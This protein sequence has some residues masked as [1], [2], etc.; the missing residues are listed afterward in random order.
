MVAQKHTDLPQGRKRKMNKKP[1]LLIYT[2]ISFCVIVAAIVVSLTAGFN[3]GSDIAGGTQIEIL[4]TGSEKSESQLISETKI[5][6]K[7][8]GVAYD[9][10]FVEDKYTD[11]YLIVRTNNKSFNKDKLTNNLAHK[12]EIE[13]ED[14]TGI[15]EISG[16]V[17]KSA[18]VWI[19]VTLALLIVGIFLASWIRYKLMTA[20]S[21]T[22]AVLH[23]IIFSTS[24]LVV[25]RIPFTLVSFIIL[26]LFSALILFAFVLTFERVL[27]NGKMVHN[28]DLSSEELIKLSKNQTLKTLLFIVCGL[29]VVA[30]ALMFVPSLNIVFNAI[31]LLVGLLS[32]T[33]SYWFI[34]L[35]LYSFMLTIKDA[36]NKRRL[37][38][39]NSPAPKKR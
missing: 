23:S 29:T 13:V 27:E 32:A 17:T 18:V 14:I 34:G 12:L 1:W 9:K 4:V 31:S 28:K 10:V 11:T 33:Y 8:N 22:I 30:L 24:L 25:T 36:A 16:F 37:S 6:F 15:Y 35:S 26:A 19:S 20:I 2:I 5:V 7:E 38:T 3:L 39:D 21:L